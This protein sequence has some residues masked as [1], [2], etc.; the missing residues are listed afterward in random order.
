MNDDLV[1]NVVYFFCAI[2]IMYKMAWIARQTG[3]IEGWHVTGLRFAG[4]AVAGIIL[5]K[6]S[7]RFIHPGDPAT[8]VDVV[9]EL[10]L[11]IFLFFAIATLRDRTGHW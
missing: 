7:M 10:A 8:L 6:A 5:L 1:L 4:V 9:R 11:C 2:C 3:H